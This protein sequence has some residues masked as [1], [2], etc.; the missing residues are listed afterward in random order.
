MFDNHDYLEWDLD[1]FGYGRFYVL[2]NCV[3]SFRLAPISGFYASREY[4][5]AWLDFYKVKVEG[6]P[7]IPL[8]CSESGL[9]L[10]HYTLGYAYLA[11]NRVPVLNSVLEQIQ[12]WESKFITCK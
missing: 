9:T 1:P 7:E 11:W 3:K 10:I 4:Y 8:Y 12:D 2:Y 5:D 6:S